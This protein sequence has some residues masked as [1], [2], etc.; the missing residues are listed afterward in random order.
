M[1]TG[2]LIA[3][4]L[5]IAAGWTMFHFLWIGAAIGLIAL[6]GRRLLRAARPEARYAFALSSLLAMAAM[7]VATFVWVFG[8]SPREKSIESIPHAFRAGTKNDLGPARNLPGESARIVSSAETTGSQTVAPGPVVWNWKSYANPVVM[9]LPWLWLAG[10]PLTFALLAG[11]LI[12]AE[13][14]RRQSQRIESGEIAQL[15]RSLAES[16]QMT[17][18]VA[19]GVCDRLLT[20][21][22]IGVIRPMILLPPAALNGWTIEQLEMVLWHEL[23][24]LRRWDNLV[25]LLQRA[26]ESLLFFHPAVW[27]ISGWARLERELCC[28]LLVVTRTGRPRAYAQT[29]ATLAGLPA[30]RQRPAAVAMAENQ[31]VLRIRRILDIEGH[32]TPMKL[33][34]W[35]VGGAA[36]LVLAP[37]FII[38]SYARQNDER[39]VNRGSRLERAQ[40]PAKTPERDVPIQRRRNPEAF[41]AA[42]RKHDVNEPEWMPGPIPETV[43]VKVSG[44]ATDEQ[45]NPV[46]ARCDLPVLLRYARHE[47]GRSGDHG[48]E[49][50]LPHRGPASRR[51]KTL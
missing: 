1:T 30:R 12:G 8:P 18:P 21:V 35:A 43:P 37:V 20:P 7:P 50:E 48:R 16:L 10:S 6:G 42:V 15:C 36:A 22:L 46:A 31:V 29:L 40:A 19:V 4:P 51:Y 13:R 45:G 44:R 2:Y 26:L 17:R 41:K 11:G 32:T 33:S 39:S 25:N 14:F 28:D 47:V 3:A 27:W 23:A 49:W 9:V 34:R 24:H 5:W 38:G